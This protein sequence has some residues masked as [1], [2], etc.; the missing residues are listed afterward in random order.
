MVVTRLR[1]GKPTNLGSISSRNNNFTSPPH[2]EDGGGAQLA[3]MYRIT[4]AVLRAEKREVPE[5]NQ[6][7]SSTFKV[8][9]KGKPN[10]TPQH[11]F[12]ACTEANFLLPGLIATYHPHTFPFCISVGQSLGFEISVVLS[13]FV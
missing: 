13:G 5:A 11:V 9:D 4:C 2:R 7:H 12:M 6:S 10:F 8:K 1:A 3:S